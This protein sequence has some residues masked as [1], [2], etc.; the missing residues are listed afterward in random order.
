MLPTQRHAA[1]LLALALAL[2]SAPAAAQ[3]PSLTQIQLNDIRTMKDKFVG[4]ANAIPE[5][6]YDWRPMEGANPP[7]RSVKE[8]VILLVNEGNNFPTQWGGTRPAGVLENRQEEAA[9]LQ[10]MNKA[11]LV[12]ELTRALDN[13]IAVVSGM[14]DAA[15]AREIRFFGQQVTVG[16]AI[17][18]A[19]ADMHEHLGQLIAYARVNRVVPP[20]ST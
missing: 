2:G 13:M 11:Q 4:L 6:A 19:T 5:N 1:T 3:T 12:G 20:W 18:M 7:V 8:V 15:R 14:D 9:R 17:M 10:A 16:G